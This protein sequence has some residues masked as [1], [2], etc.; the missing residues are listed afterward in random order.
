MTSDRKRKKAARAYKASHDGT[1]GDALRAVAISPGRGRRWRRATKALG[2]PASTLVDALARFLD[3]RPPA[4]QDVLNLVEQTLT[5]LKEVPSRKRPLQDDLTHAL[6]KADDD[7]TVEIPAVIPSVRGAARFI[8]SLLADVDDTELI[9]VATD[10]G[11]SER[12]VSYA[13]YLIHEEHRRSTTVDTGPERETFLFADSPE[14]EAEESERGARRDAQKRAQT[15]TVARLRN[16]NEG[17]WEPIDRDTLRLAIAMDLAA[18]GDAFLTVSESPVP[19]PTLTWR[20]L[21]NGCTRADMLIPMATMPLSAVV[22]P[23]PRPRRASEPASTPEFYRPDRRRSTIA[24]TCYV[25][26][27][28]AEVD[29][30]DSFGREFDKYDIDS[31][32]ASAAAAQFA[33]AQMVGRIA[34]NAY[35]ARSFPDGRVLIP[36]EVGQ[37]D[38]ETTLVF[39]LSI[40]LHYSRYEISGV[41]KLWCRLLM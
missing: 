13:A 32:Y 35:S 36:R 40:A 1:Y 3:R 18:M 30:F 16:H 27:F 33:C 37:P 2:V 15:D 23:N 12:T 39:D 28:T 8:K 25:G 41:D 4:T 24:Y 26:V 19:P 14:A 7:T 17:A 31:S 29:E 21:A 38:D 6:T 20:P 10:L 34:S 5:K 22:K 9:A 11:V